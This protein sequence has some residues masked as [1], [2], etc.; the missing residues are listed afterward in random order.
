MDIP[1]PQ[2]NNVK[3]AELCI[4]NSIINMDVTSTKVNYK[5]THVDINKLNLYFGMDYDEIG[6][7]ESG[8]VCY[9]RINKTGRISYLCKNYNLTPNLG[10]IDFVKLKSREIL[11]AEMKVE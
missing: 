8:S 9:N 6:V 3:D 7:I 5:F 1:T 4:A 11:I 2:K 10:Y